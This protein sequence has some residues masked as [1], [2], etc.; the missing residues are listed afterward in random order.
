MLV[1]AFALSVTVNAVIGASF[2]HL[3]MRSPKTCPTPSFHA[4]HVKSTQYSGRLPL[5]GPNEEKEQRQRNG[6]KG[7]KLFRFRDRFAHIVRAGASRRTAPSDL[8]RRE[9]R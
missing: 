2:P 9:D 1:L 4:A 6:E 3:S 5:L 7:K 8:T